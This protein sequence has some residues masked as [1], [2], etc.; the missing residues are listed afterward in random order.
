MA[1]NENFRSI[2]DGIGQ[3]LTNLGFSAYKNENGEFIT[4]ADEKI[5]A[6]YTGEKG[7]IAV[8]YED[9]KV[10]LYAGEDIEAPEE[11]PKKLSA[12]LLGEEADSRDV[13][14]VVNELND[15]L[16]SK[17][18]KKTVAPKKAVQ[19]KATQT[20]SKAAV[21]HGSFYDPNTLTSKLCL[22]F[23]EL[24]PYYKDNLAVYGEFLAEKFFDDYGTAKVIDA[25]KANDPQTMKKLFQVLNEIYED[26][27]SEV[28]DVIAVTILGSLNNDQ[29]LLAR[30]V[31]YM[32][33]TMAPPVIEVNKL[34]AK[35]KK[36]RKLL[37]NPPAYKPKKEKKPGMFAQ[38]MAQSGGGMTPPAM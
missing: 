13:K 14:Y 38:A 29:I 17:Y 16:H 34:L 11:T 6:R 22:V 32:S 26:G 2:L 12:S 18:S 30:C 7:V 4:E 37:E 8:S 21:K 28:Q 9:G 24:R 27:T 20:V 3:E 25:I 33:T 36:A 5:T 31:D 1:I 15:T 19:Q 23:P 10:I 35:S